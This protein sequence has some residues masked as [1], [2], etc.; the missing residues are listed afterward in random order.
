MRFLSLLLLAVACFGQGGFQNSVQTGIVDAH[1]A[2]WRFP[3]STFSALPSPAAGN[4]GW[5]YTVTDGLTSACTAGGG[6]TKVDVG[7]D[8]SST[9][10]VISGGSGGGGASYLGQILDLQLTRTDGTHLSENLV[11]NIRTADGVTHSFNSVETITYVSGAGDAFVYLDGITRGCTV[12]STSVLTRTAAWT[13]V[14]G[15]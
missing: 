10:T 1:G 14:T 6:S 8:G 12:G 2:S 7:S 11:G 4:L 5:R 13:F 3:E 15:I 9:W